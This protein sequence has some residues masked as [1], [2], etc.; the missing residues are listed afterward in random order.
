MYI[1]VLLKEG[2]QDPII[3]YVTTCEVGRE[4]VCLRK[5]LLGRPLSPTMIN[6]EE[7]SR[8]LKTLKVCVYLFI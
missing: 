3:E 4:V 5:L 1:E 7:K 6:C 2:K 8:C